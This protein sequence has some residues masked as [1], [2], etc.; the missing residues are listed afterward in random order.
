MTQ[1]VVQ[2]A[3]LTHMPLAAVYT[4]LGYRAGYSDK[5]VIQ[6]EYEA[7][8][9]HWVATTRVR[10]F[11]LFQPFGVENGICRLGAHAFAS[12][13]IAE[14]FARASRTLLMAASADPADFEKIQKFSEAGD[15]KTS[16]VLDAVLSEK[17]DFALDFLETELKV[18]FRREGQL[19]GARLSCGYGDFKLEN[20][21]VLFETLGLANYG[22]TLDE[23]FILHPE[24]TVTALAPIYASN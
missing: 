2:W 17:V 15:L 13:L 5:T 4:R 8:L 11:Y 22:I 10:I 21:Q 3:P 1:P 16:V 20:Q 18:Q 7:L 24:K 14:R 23:R 19:L 9:K 6:A 12:R